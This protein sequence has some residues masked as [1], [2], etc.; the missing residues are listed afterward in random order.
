MAESASAK[1]RAAFDKAGGKKSYE[2]AKAAAHKVGEAQGLSPHTVRS[3]LS[4]WTSGTGT[5]KKATA[6]ATAKAA[7]KRQARKADARPVRQV[8]KAAVRQPKKAQAEAAA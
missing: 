1:V 2:A 4:R 3:H 7:P 6:K 8:K 5:A